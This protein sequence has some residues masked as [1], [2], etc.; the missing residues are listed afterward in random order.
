M[1]PLL[2][3]TNIKRS[4]GAIQALRGADFEI[5][6][7]EVIGLVGENGAGKSTM[8][9]IISGFDSGFTGEYLLNG[10]AL[11]FNSPIQAERAGIAVA[12]Q[13]LSLIKTMSVAENIFLAGDKVPTF[14]TKR[15]LSRMAKPF[16][17]E[18]GLGHID[19]SI[20]TDRL[21]IGE[22]HLIEVAR[23]LAHDPQLLILD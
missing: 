15:S 17:E 11:H 12:Q 5:M 18:V 16:L 10:E 1:Q 19:P 8:V 6:P 13:E 9:K 3:L 2:K 7:G 4:Y 23:L 21:S 20:A 22:Q 14:A